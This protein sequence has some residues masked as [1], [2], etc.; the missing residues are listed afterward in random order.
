MRSERGWLAVYHVSW[1]QV[2]QH[3]QGPL[4]GAT[5]VALLLALGGTLVLRAYRRSVIEPLRSNHARLLESEAFSRTILDNAPIGLCLLRRSDG[6][7]PLDNTLARRW[8]GEDHHTGGLGTVPW[9]RSVLAA[10]GTTLGDG[11]AYTTLEGRHLLVTA[12]PAALPRRA[13]GAVPVHR[14][15]Q[16]ARSRA[17]AAAGA[18]C[19]R[20]VP[21]GPRASSRPP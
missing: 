2:F 15:Q 3:P 5:V 11:L 18:P 8:L 17:G 6:N 9:R 10:G 7:V 1:R 19:R 4:L 16:P 20:P 21:T 12:T 14:S 13:G